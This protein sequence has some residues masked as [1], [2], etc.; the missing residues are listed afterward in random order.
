ME[1]PSGFSATIRIPS[2]RSVKR[3]L[4]AL[5]FPKEI[6]LWQRKRS[7]NLPRSMIVRYSMRLMMPTPLISRPTLPVRDQVIRAELGYLDPKEFPQAKN[8]NPRDF[9][10]N[11]FV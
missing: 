6:A 11:S 10:D 1:Q 8:A 4:K 3:W 9:F 2:M 7:A 5:F